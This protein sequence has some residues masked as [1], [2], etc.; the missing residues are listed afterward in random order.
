MPHGCYAQFLN[1]EITMSDHMWRA[2]D[3]YFTQTLVKPDAALSSALA[4]NAAA[5]LP[6]IDVAANQ[7]KLLYLLAR[8]MNASRI[9]EIGT[10]GGYSTLWLARAL[11]EGGKIVTLEFSPQHAQV[12]RENFA[13]AGVM[14]K[15]E[16]LVGPALESLPTLQG[17][18]DMIFIDADKRNNPHYLRWA[19]KL[20]RVG[21]V[22]IGDNVVRSGRIVDSQS[23]DEN[24]QGLRQY[25]RDI[26][27]NPHLTATALQT[28]GSKGWDGLQLAIVESLPD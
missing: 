3:D 21:S 18:F 12:P 19:L 13:E 16:L 6:P 28:V 1:K 25:L 9:L 17:T 14:D 8:M 27:E 26:G 10:L 5:G 2:V 23:T 11:P 24:V 15:V 22:I 7:G 4:R 20:A